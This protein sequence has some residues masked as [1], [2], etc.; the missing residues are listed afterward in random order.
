MSLN[1]HILSMHKVTNTQHTHKIVS[2][3]AYT[4]HRVCHE[5]QWLYVNVHKK[6]HEWVHVYASA[7]LSSHPVEHL[8][9]NIHTAFLPSLVLHLPYYFLVV[10]V[11]LATIN[12]LFSHCGYPM[13]QTAPVLTA[14]PHDFHHHFQNCVYGM[15]YDI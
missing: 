4:A 12:T 2:D 3:I 1:T 9:V 8:L 10:W 6:H 11:C 7:A 15:I 14:I 5:V 13:H